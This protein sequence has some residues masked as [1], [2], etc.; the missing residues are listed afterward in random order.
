MYVFKKSNKVKIK[1]LII[2]ILSTSILC[3]N[4][5]SSKVYSFPK[6]VINKKNTLQI[7]T[8][9][10]IQKKTKQKEKKVKSK[11]SKK[12]VHNVNLIKL[13]Q[14]QNLSKISKRKN[15]AI[16]KEVFQILKCDT[17]SDGVIYKNI[18]IG[19]G[20]L[21]HSVH[22]LEADIDNENIS[23][24]PIKAGKT[25]FDLSKLH[26]IIKS[27][28]QNHQNNVLGAVNGSFWKAYNNFPIGITVI[29]GE[30]AELLNYKNWSNALFDDR[31]KLT[32]DRVSIIGKIKYKN[33]I[34]SNITSVN[35]RRDSIGVV[36]YNKYGGDTIPFIQ[37]ERFEEILKIALA[38]ELNDRMYEDSTEEAFDTL[39]LKQD[40][41]SNQRNSMIE[42]S[43]N[44]IVL[45]YLTPC[46]INS[47]IYCLVTRVDTGCVAIP[48]NGCLLSLGTDYRQHIP[49]IGDTI[50]LKYEIPKYPK[51][52]FLHIITAT[53]RIV[54][55]GIAN[56]EAYEEGSRGRR[57][58][59]KSL[60]RTAIGTNRGRDKIFLITVEGTK[61]SQGT[62]GA[63]LSQLAIIS[64]KIGCYNAMNLDGGGSSAMVINNRNLLYDSNPATSRRIS[65]GIGVI[66][67]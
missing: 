23:V 33:S 51:T 17:L 44:K 60:P 29:N 52:H 25:N 62:F 41:L 6:K 20:K 47:D 24:E 14:K 35:R 59:N 11:T 13:K 56:Q 38:N 65:V 43:L 66:E 34:I 54:R 61:K 46:I 8:S 48:D 15:K 1:F 12:K 2:F 55:N 3:F 28:E 37:K 22:I 5:S 67:K 9:G 58:V 50:V 57:F 16:S 31:G 7:N 21:I 27:Q 36:V 42:Y 18:R 26:E 19:K 30:V 63:S 4:F 64:K 40:I 10:R 49:K 39:K 45:K 32:I 53:P